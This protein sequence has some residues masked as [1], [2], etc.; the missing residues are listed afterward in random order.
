VHADGIEG[1]RAGARLRVDFSEVFRPYAG[2][3]PGQ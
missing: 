3:Q 1:S 2:Q